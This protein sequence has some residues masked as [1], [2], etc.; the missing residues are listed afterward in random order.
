MIRLIFIF[1]TCLN[2]LFGGEN[3]VK[4]ETDTVFLFL[5]KDLNSS[6]LILTQDSLPAVKNNGKYCYVTDEIYNKFKK[7]NEAVIS[8]PKIPDSL[9]E[10]KPPLIKNSKIIKATKNENFYFQKDKIELKV[11]GKYVS[12]RGMCGM[13]ASVI[14]SLKVNGI[15]FFKQLYMENWCGTNVNVDKIEIDFSKKEVQLFLSYANLI[16]INE[17]FKEIKFV[18]IPFSYFE[19]NTI[20]SLSLSNLA[21]LLNIYCQRNYDCHYYNIKVGFL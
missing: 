21:K 18:T 11:D 13:V 9:C 15:S 1:L 3:Y 10:D 14:L 6:Q 16:G 2:L 8:Y 17:K 19:K 12:G 7:T 20:S 4:F 5:Q